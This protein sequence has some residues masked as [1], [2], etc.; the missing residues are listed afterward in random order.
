LLAV[1][2]SFAEVVTPSGLIVGVGGAMTVDV[3]RINRVATR[4]VKALASKEFGTPLPASHK[5]VTCLAEKVED[6]RI[7]GACVELLKQPPT[8]IWDGF[9]PTGSGGRMKT[10][11]RVFGSW[12]FLGKS[13]SSA[14]Q[15]HG[16]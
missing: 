14:S 4:I 3:A 8:R 2:L 1:N 11:T 5:T 16:K 12:C 13:G 6:E 7:R 15:D 10:L 9:L